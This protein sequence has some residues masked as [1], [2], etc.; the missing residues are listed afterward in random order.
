MLVG[1]VDW[2]MPMLKGKQR[3]RDLRRNGQRKK[4]SQEV[5]ITAIWAGE[6]FHP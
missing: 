6:N 4:E 1:A 5:T 3:R 2:D